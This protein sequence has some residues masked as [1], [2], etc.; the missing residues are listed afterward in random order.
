MPPQDL[1]RCIE[2]YVSVAQRQKK[3]DQYKD[4]N[5]ATDNYFTVKKSQLKYRINKPCI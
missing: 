3:Q 4:L 1:R 2:A 5:T